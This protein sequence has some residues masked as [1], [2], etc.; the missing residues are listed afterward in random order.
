MTALGFT[1]HFC[2]YAVQSLKL[3]GQTRQH[4]GQPPRLDG[5]L[6][7]PTMRPTR[8]AW[9]R[10]MAASCA[11][12]AAHSPPANR[13]APAALTGPLSHRVA[14]ARV[15]EALNRAL[16]VIVTFCHPLPPH[17][18]R[19]RQSPD[20]LRSQLPAQRVPSVVLLP[21]IASEHPS[22]LC[23]SAPAC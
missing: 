16:G 4:A 19:S 13:R 9:T 8:M 17:D 14:S 3:I 10:S 12:Y 1:V 21:C 7:S 22:V 20:H 11:V 2:I 18:S 23:T 5:L 6:R 15:S